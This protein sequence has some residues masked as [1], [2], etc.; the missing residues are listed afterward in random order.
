LKFAEFERTRHVV[1]GQVAI[2]MT[3][4]LVFCYVQNK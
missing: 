1:A 3:I 4:F 2:S